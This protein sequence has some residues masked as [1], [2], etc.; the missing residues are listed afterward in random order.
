MSTTKK[1]YQ[2]IKPKFKTLEEKLIDQ[3]NEDD[4]IIFDEIIFQDDELYWSD[5][6]FLKELILSD[7]TNQ[8]SKEV[9]VD[10]GDDVYDIT[11]G[12][13]LTYLILA[14]PFH[15][16]KKSFNGFEFEISDTSALNNYM[17][18]IIHYFKNEFD[19]SINDE[20]IDI[21]SELSKLSS[22]I[23]G[24]Y[25]FTINLYDLC[26]LINN[27]PEFKNLMNFKLS[28]TNIH[29]LDF[30]QSLDL[31]DS[32]FNEVLDILKTEDNCYKV[33]L[34]SNIGLSEKQLKD[35]IF[36]VSFKPDMVGNIINI[37]VDT[38]YIRGNNI[39]TYYIDCVGGRKA[40]I[41]NFKNTKK[42]GYLT[43][44]L[45]ILMIDN[46]I[47]HDIDDCG[48]KQTINAFIPNQKS[49][50]KLVYRNYYDSKGK[51]RHIDPTKDTHLIGKTIRLRSPAR[52]ALNGKYICK[53]CYGKLWKYNIGKNVGIIASLILNNQNTQT[54]LSAK[55]SITANL[56]KI[57]WGDD[58]NKYF[59]IDKEKIML[60]EKYCDNRKFNIC[61]P[62]F[63]ESDI[64]DSNYIFDRIVIEEF[65]KDP[66]TIDLPKSFI[67]NE[68]VIPN[69]DDK[70][71]ENKEMYVFNS[72]NIFSDDILFTYN[73]QNN[74]LSSSL[75]SIINLIESHSFIKDNDLDA[76][77]NKFISLLNE[78]PLVIHSIHIEIILKELSMIDNDDRSLFKKPK[79]K[80][81]DYPILEFKRVTDAIINSPYVTK[82][83]MY[84]EQSKQLTQ[85]PETYTKRKE[86]V[87]DILLT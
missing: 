45:T 56:S 84:Q 4:T 79:E 13:L 61:I 55:H 40:L 12:N 74:E 73:M 3:L 53:T 62:E 6:V 19:I 47:S 9:R 63:H 68:D 17:S 60:N 44:K 80:D 87:L 78:S 24:V 8:K 34:L 75:N 11:Q 57:N 66:V 51:L 33:L 18:D 21:I 16:Y 14:L 35:T 86:S 82:S 43:R 71:K 41:I 42:S 32:K 77:Y 67:I 83:Y 10:F 85:M 54:Q 37:P 28:D 59:I 25:G 22:M 29:N 39:V 26:T 20:L 1:G 46:Y 49:L 27:N 30:K 81:S 50:N 23:L 58:F 5:I 70:Y 52:C 48:T 38:S 64:F 2:K 76:I 15:I 31:V 7:F 72:S 65:K 36:N 69:I